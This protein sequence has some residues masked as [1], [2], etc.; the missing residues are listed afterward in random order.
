MNKET[1][2]LIAKWDRKG[3]EELQKMNLCLQKRNEM[4]FEEPKL[5]FYERAQHH[6]FRARLC[7]MMVYRLKIN[8]SALV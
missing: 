1:Q 4:R 3:R 2:Q 6:S 7:F 5:H 8:A